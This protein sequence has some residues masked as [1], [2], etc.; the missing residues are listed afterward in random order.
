MR[1]ELDRNIKMLD[2]SIV[3]SLKMVKNQLENLITEI[4]YGE[5]EH[6]LVANALNFTKQAIEKFEGKVVKELA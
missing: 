3:F 2:E 6:F 1:N 5:D 4:P